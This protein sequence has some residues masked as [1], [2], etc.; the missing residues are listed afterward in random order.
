[1]GENRLKPC[2]FCGKMAKHYYGS[3]QWGVTCSKCTCVIRGYGSQAA[4]TRAWN[5][6]DEKALKQWEQRRENR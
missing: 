5:H 3:F 4:A 6:R 2:P 1:M